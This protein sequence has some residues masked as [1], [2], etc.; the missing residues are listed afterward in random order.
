MFVFVR[1]DTA[2][3][4]C[5]AV[6]ELDAIWDAIVD[7]AFAVNRCPDCHDLRFLSGLHRTCITYIREAS[8]GLDDLLHRLLVDILSMLVVSFTCSLFFRVDEF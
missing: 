5:A 6:M 8:D 3:V 2:A 7:D 4:E 1:V